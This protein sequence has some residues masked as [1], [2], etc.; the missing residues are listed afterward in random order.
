M[1]RQ[2]PDYRNENIM[3]AQ[4]ITVRKNASVDFPGI[5]IS[6]DVLYLA[7]KNA[8]VLI[9]SETG[10]P[11]RLSVNLDAY[12]LTPRPGFVFIKDWSEGAGVAASLAKD[13]LVEITA[14]HMVGP[15]STT[16]YEVRV[17]L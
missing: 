12:G 2:F 5:K 17:V 14:S 6:G 10:G 16:A 13:G 3:N 8:L 1:N 4:P 9:D 11:E 15:F 7:D